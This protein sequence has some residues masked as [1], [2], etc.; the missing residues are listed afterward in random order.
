MPQI[1]ISG[2]V[3][4]KLDSYKNSEGFK[5]YN[6]AVNLL[7]SKSV[8][9]ADLMRIVKENQQLL[10]DNLQLIE[11]HNQNLKNSQNHKK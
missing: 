6:E 7:I 1:E 4:K 2:V 3:K 11:K 8:L 9:N 5:T 10:K